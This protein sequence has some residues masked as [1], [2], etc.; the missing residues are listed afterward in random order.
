M[1]LRDAHAIVTGHYWIC[2]PCGRALRD[3]GV[4]TVKIHQTHHEL[5]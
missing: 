4:T 5:R 1:T 3:A 2:E